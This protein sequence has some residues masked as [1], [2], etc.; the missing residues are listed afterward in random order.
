MEVAQR[1]R[2]HTHTHRIQHIVAAGHEHVVRKRGSAHAG[3]VHLGQCDR[4]A[5]YRVGA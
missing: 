4:A 2:P 5:A 3:A 1:A